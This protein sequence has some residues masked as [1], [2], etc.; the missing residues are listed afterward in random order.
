MIAPLRPSSQP[1]TAW[2]VAALLAAGQFTF[3][4]ALQPLVGIGI[5][6]QSEPV[7][8]ANS[9]LAGLVL[10]TLAL[11]RTSP[12][13]PPGAILIVIA[14]AGWAAISLPFAVS[15]AGTWLGTPQSGHGIGW[16]LTVAA[17]AT[18]VS[19]LRGR[20]GPLA[21]VVMSSAGSAV[22]LMALNRWAPMAWRPQ[23]FTD[24][25]AF[26]A[27]F[28]WMALMAW[29][30]NR[31]VL[32][33]FAGLGLVGLVIVSD[34][35]SAYVAVLA[36]AVGTALAIW[37]NRKPYGRGV[38][39]LLPVMAAISVTIGVA[40]FGQYDLLRNVSLSLRDT[41]ISRANMMRVVGAELKLEPQALLFGRGWGSFDVALSR[42]MTLD[43]VALQPLASDEFLFWDAAHR[44]DFHPHNEVVE[45]TL[46]GGIPAGIALIM[47]FGM[48]AYHAPRRLRVYVV[49]FSITLAALS[50]MWFQLPTSVPAFGVAAGMVGLSRRRGVSGKAL[51]V[52]LGAAGILLV[53][54]ASVLWLRAEAGRREFADTTPKECA[55][56]FAGQARI[57]S[58]WLIQAQWHRLTEALQSNAPSDE[59]AADAIRMRQRLCAAD[60]MASAKDGLPLAVEA[61]IIRSDLDIQSWPATA[62]ELRAELLRTIKDGLEI[63]LKMAPQRSD[64]AAPYLSSLLARGREAELVEFVA[65]HL[66]ADDPV[67]LWYSGIVMLNSPET[68]PSGVKRL[69]KAMRLGVERFI[70]IPRDL[71]RQLAEFGNSRGSD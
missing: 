62:L 41:V 25:G 61:T 42:S 30:P 19:S 38:M 44:N 37:M 70:I 66:A 45:A 15:M 9:G 63:T 29:K 32:A 23:H 36:G 39:A 4:L 68:L 5:W 6:F 52:A 65:R 43:G 40:V 3:V 47:F 71:K 10:I 53:A 57:H 55:P 27:I 50:C 64:L 33:V 59:I 16:L 31:R 51:R 69:Q 60:I 34:N 54:T 11:R 22:I 12:R 7:S 14:M 13:L 49:G 48:L 20:K 28:A 24:V 17:F 35:R 56:L 8:A 58:V 1:V 21:L 18:G 2:I 67:G 46:S 26:N